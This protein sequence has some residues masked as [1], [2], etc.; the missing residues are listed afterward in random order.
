MNTSSTVRACVTFFRVLRAA[1]GTEAPVSKSAALLAGGGR[2]HGEDPR[3][4]F[5]LFTALLDLGPGCEGYART[6]HGGVF[7]V[8]LDEVMGTAANF[9]SREFF[10]PCPASPPPLGETL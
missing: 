9:Q 1:A 7:P 2:D 6:L 8:I 3:N 10:P 4:P 5:L